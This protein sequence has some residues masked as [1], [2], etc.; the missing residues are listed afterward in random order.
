MISAEP[1]NPDLAELIRYNRAACQ[2]PADRCPVAGPRWRVGASYRCEACFADVTKL[3]W[4]RA[5]AQLV[6]D[7]VQIPLEGSECDMSDVAGHG[8][9]TF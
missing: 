3:C 4:E 5:Y 7:A 8:D 2:H 9:L 6:R 1:E